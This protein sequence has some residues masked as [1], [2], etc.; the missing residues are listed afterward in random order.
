MAN[1]PLLQGL[2]SDDEDEF[3]DDLNADES[4]LGELKF[5]SEEMKRFL[6]YDEEPIQSP[7]SMEEY[8]VRHM[9][10]SWVLDDPDWKS[11]AASNRD[12]ISE[13][14]NIP[15]HLRSQ[16]Q[17]SAL[18]HWL[19][20]IWGTAN[21]MGFKKCAS[22][23]KVFHFLVYEPGQS[24]ITEGEHG[25]TF[26]IIISGTCNIHKEGIGVVA[27][28]GKGKSF[29]EIALTEGNSLRTATVLA[30]S[31]YASHSSKCTT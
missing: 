8:S 4:S 9:F 13:I 2:S 24:I 25:M 30:D 28:I 16:E 26:F 11:T 3:D 27:N 15:Y 6:Q 17:T 31:R 23:S 22:M 29:G 1:V 21:Q 14:A 10:P 7:R 18:V 19:M 12:Q 20:S 5:A